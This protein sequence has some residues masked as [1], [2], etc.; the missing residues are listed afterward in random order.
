MPKRHTVEKIG[1]TTM[2]QF[3]DVM[4][5]VIIGK[6]KEN[7]LYNRIFVVSAYGGITDLLLE[8]KKTREPGVYGV[9]AEDK[10]EWQDKLE[11][12]RNRML[13]LDRKSV[14]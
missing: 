12:V 3:K 7:E 5:N 14:V 1:G 4:D 6:R 9:F 2:T 10:R 13:E 8:N 11:L